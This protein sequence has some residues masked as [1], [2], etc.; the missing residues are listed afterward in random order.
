MAR[1]PRARRGAKPFDGA[2]PPEPTGGQD[3]TLQMQGP[4]RSPKVRAPNLNPIKLLEEVLPETCLINYACKLRS[5]RVFLLCMQT[6]TELL[7]N[8]HLYYRLP[9]L[10]TVATRNTAPHHDF[11]AQ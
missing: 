11:G 7:K 4:T 10:D 3:T 1:V 2:V 8:M 6:D 5:S 9:F